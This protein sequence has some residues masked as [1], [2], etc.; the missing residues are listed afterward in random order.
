MN[1]KTA[2]VPPIKIRDLK[3]KLSKTTLKSK[4]KKKT[5]KIQNFAGTPA[6][7]TLLCEIF[8]DFQ[9]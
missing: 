8:P 1:R 2:L 9:E 5:S 4:T 7:P 3:S 6:T